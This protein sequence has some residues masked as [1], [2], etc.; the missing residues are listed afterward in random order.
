LE[1]ELSA[2]ENDQKEE[3]R[4]RHDLVYVSPQFQD[5][6]VLLSGNDPIWWENN[7]TV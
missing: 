7:A 1:F 4:L 2:V 6:E 5:R 3:L